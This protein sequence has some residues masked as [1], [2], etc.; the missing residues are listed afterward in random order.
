MNRRQS[1]NKG[2]RLKHYGWPDLLIVA[3]ALLVV[4]VAVLERDWKFLFIG[5]GL[6]AIVIIRILVTQWLERR[7]GDESPG[8]PQ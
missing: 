5:L 7:G 4:P 3:G 8:E 1:P 2:P 6:V